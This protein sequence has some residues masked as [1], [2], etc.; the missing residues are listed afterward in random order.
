VSTTL[1]ARLSAHGLDVVAMAIESYASGQHPELCCAHSLLAEF[2][3]LLVEAQDAVAGIETGALTREDAE[4]MCWGYEPAPETKRSIRQEIEAP[5]P[6]V[7]CLPP[8]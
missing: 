1:T 6:T 4:Q 8:V 3:A 2:R 5:E 7:P